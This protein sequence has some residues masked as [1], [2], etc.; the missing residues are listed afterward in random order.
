MATTI[1]RKFLEIETL[2]KSII[3][4]LIDGKITNGNLRLTCSS[5]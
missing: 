4:G 3:D 5:F 1:D 2:V